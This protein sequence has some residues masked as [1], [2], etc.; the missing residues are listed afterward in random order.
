[1]LTSYEVALSNYSKTRNDLH[2]MVVQEPHWPLQT[3]HRHL[4]L[5]TRHRA[6]A[7]KWF[8]IGDQHA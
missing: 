4:R 2:E 1:M 5:F 7:S 8:E 3:P 6:V